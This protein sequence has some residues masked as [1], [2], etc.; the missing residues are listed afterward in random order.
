MCSLRFR[1]IAAAKLLA[2]LVGA[3]VILSPARLL[4][5]GPRYVA[6]VTFFNPG[7]AGQP[8]RWANGQLNYYVDQGPLN[9][10][11]DNQHATAMVD[12]AAQL[13]AR[14]RRRVYRWSG[15]VR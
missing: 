5:G 2:G 8:L 6:G 10:T 15:R 7:V 1:S 4:A 13:W 11:I 9:S 3:A 14:C 12:R